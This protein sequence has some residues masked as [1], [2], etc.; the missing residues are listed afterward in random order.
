MRE[1]AKGIRLHAQFF[2]VPS[3]VETKAFI[4]YHLC[5]WGRG[6]PQNGLIK[7]NLPDHFSI[8]SKPLHC[9]VYSEQVLLIYLDTS[10]SLLPSL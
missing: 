7:Y 9:I 3:Q 5:T 10:L 4:P 8:Q 1:L 6:V 2:H